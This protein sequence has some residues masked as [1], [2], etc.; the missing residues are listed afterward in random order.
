V[1][2]TASAARKQC[3][4]MDGSP[5][6]SDGGDLSKLLPDDYALGASSI[7]VHL[8]PSH[9]E[10]LPE[11]GWKLHLSACLP[12]A[13]QLLL[14]FIENINKIGL[15]CKFIKAP[16]DLERL[17]AG[18]LSFTQIGKFITIYC[19]TVEE[20][21]RVVGILR[22]MTRDIIGPRVPSDK[23]VPGSMCMYYRYGSISKN[24]SLLPMERSP[25]RAV[26]A[27]LEDPFKSSDEWEDL[28]KGLIPT[29]IIS[30]R[31]K[32]IIF[33]AIDITRDRPCNVVAK[34]FFLCG[35]IESDGTD[36][37]RRGLWH[38]ECL[39]R[40]TGLDVSSSVLR[41]SQASGDLL[42]VEE[43]CGPKT[44][45]DTYLEPDLFTHIIAGLR[46]IHCRGIVMNDV[47]PNNIVVADDGL[48][49]FVDFDRAL[50]EGGPSQVSGTTG[51]WTKYANL[52]AGP[53]G[54]FWSL[55]S[56]AASIDRSADEFSALRKFCMAHE[57]DQ[58]YRG[59]VSRSSS[60]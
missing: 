4:G 57:W 58:F 33:R 21:I 47:S 9:A 44:L 46:S 51:F 32:G 11:Y 49:R 48:P 5:S 28:Y 20:L 25:G 37:V 60:S 53:D 30:L 10:E 8:Q 42:V 56:I 36:A 35:A 13:R 31:D 26:P 24:A 19:G 41:T 39:D 7:F 45:A 2:L 43:D 50:A 12:Q 40:L 16:A 6:Y 3:L 34:H 23:R 22:P 18:L 52:A 38:V 14:V 29:E 54:D 1:E 27:W 15:P 17:N 59:F 55:G